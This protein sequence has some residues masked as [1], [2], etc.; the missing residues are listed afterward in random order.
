MFGGEKRMGTSNP[1]VPRE[2]IHFSDSLTARYQSLIRLAEAIRGGRNHEELFGI[3]ADEL[4]RVVQFDGIAQY[5]ESANKVNWRYCNAAIN[6]SQNPIAGLVKE[7]TVAWW[8]HAHQEPVLVP[9]IETETRFP[10]T[11]ERLRGV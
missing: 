3:L 1:P 10:A 5:D 2:D 6:P 11:I 8:V 9:C 4:Q 7:Q